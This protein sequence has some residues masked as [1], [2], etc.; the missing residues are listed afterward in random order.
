MDHNP[1]LRS[2]RQFKPQREAA[3]GIIERPD[4]TANLIHQTRE[5]PP[6][7]YENRLGEALE[8][9][10]ANDVVELNEIVNCLNEMGVQTPDGGS[11]TEQL[12][13]SEMECLG[14]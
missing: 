7:D 9:I 6:T 4:D 2:Y 11:W 5:S 1:H 14:A 13:R 12:F 10:F 3:K 8:K